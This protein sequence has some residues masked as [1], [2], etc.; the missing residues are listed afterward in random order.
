MGAEYKPQR[1]IFFPRIPITDGSVLA[2]LVNF[3]DRV[4]VLFIVQAFGIAVG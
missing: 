4:P 3:S 2:V 1:F